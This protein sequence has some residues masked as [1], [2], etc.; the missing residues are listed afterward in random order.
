MEQK[1][2]F[3][4]NSSAEV[5]IGIRRRLKADGILNY[6]AGKVFANLKK[7]SGNTIKCENH[8]WPFALIFVQRLGLT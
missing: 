5:K 2:S 6:P 1:C 7:T 4:G 8:L 3:A